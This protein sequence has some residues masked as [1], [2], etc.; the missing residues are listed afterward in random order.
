MDA[1]PNLPELIR[2]GILAMVRGCGAPPLSPSTELS[3]ALG[4]TA[5]P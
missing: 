1:W 2:A 5:V 4:K 3:E